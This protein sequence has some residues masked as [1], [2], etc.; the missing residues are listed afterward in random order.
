MEQSLGKKIA[1]N[2]KRLNMTQDQL[3]EKLGVTAQAVSKWENDQSCP[4]ITM[5]PKLAEI[6]GVSTDTLLGCEKIPTVTAEVVQEHDESD[7]KEPSGIHVNFGKGDWAFNWDSGRMGALSF[8]IFVLLV[9]VLYL[10]DRILQ[11]SIGLWG[12]LW[13]SGLLVFGLFGLFRRRFSILSLC[14]ALAGAYFLLD[15]F[16]LFPFQLGGDLLWPVLIVVF[17]I[18]LLL[19]AL[20]KP[21]RPHFHVTHTR[22]AKNNKD[23]TSDYSATEDSFDCSQSFG[24][25]RRE[26]SLAR[27]R[28]GEISN[29]FG[30]LTVDLSGVEEVAESC[31]VEVSC[32]FGNLVLLIPRRFRV[33]PNTCTAFANLE[34]SGHP[35]PDPEGIINLDADVSFG[36]IEVIYI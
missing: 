1:A 10:A 29:S 27:L 8:A 14:S 36:N 2:R 25:A 9:G 19:D 35:D 30:E 22:N 32:A 11:Q 20:R 31:C 12:I 18:S 26:V 7:E 23:V 6:F 24:E 15:G 13:P 4:D 28:H 33:E 5:L 17:G 34:V 3:A 21:K 16:Q